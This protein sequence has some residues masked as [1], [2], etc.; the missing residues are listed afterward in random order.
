[1]AESETTA[2]TL[3]QPKVTKI[4]E[5]F[6]YE[7]PFAASRVIGLIIILL[8]VVAVTGAIVVEV[9]ETVGCPFIL[10]PEGGVDPIKTPFQ[11]TLEEVRTAEGRA[12]EQGEVLFIIRGAEIQKRHT[13]L[14]AFEQDLRAL[15]QRE[16][17][18]E[19]DYLTRRQI[20]EAEIAQRQKEVAYQN[21]YLK[22]HRDFLER[23]KELQTAGL[24]SPVDML[25]QQL[26]LAEAERDVAIAQQAHEMAKLNLLQLETA[27]EMKVTETAIERSKIAVHVDALRKQ[28]R[29]CEG[30]VVQVR[31]PFDATVLALAVR[32]VGDVVALGQELGQLARADA[33]PRARLSVAEQG[34]PRLR[35][36]LPVK[37]YLE[38]FPYQRYGT[39]HGV[40]EWISP[41]TIASAAGEEFVAYVHVDKLTMNVRGEARPLRAGMRGEA[42]VTVGQRSLIEYAFEPLRRL[43]ENM[44]D[45][46]AA[47]EG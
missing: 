4:T 45:V 17:P 11:G 33:T 38:A 7:M 29:D 31:A 43:R 26:G 13:E 23:M 44:V 16:G 22:A 1:M 6:P 10:V 9:P 32:Q 18:L 19:K 25:S 2:R 47:Q 20:Q 41:A 40:L 21:E 15:D 8:F 14:R 24:A 42:R 27:R 37:L 34:V 30:D 36:G 35:E 46:G 28:L 5:L 3:E 39:S 12:V